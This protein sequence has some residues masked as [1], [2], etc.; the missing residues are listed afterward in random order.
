MANFHSAFEKTMGHEGYYANDPHD[1]GG[2]TYRGVARNR[3]E[4]WD[5]WQIID[6]LRSTPNFPNNLN[7]E[8]QL[9]AS[10]EQFYKKHFWNRFQGD[11][12]TDQPLA[13]ELFDTSVNLGISRAVKFLQ[14]GLNVLN[15][16][17]SLYG[18]ISVDGQFGP[19]TLNTLNASLNAGQGGYLLKVINILQ[20]EHYV[21]LM[22]NNPVMEKY[23]RGWLNR[24][25]VTRG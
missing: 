7:R 9:Q 11:A 21:T 24:V 14:R 6:D 19:K 12:V 13:E 3:H 5:G 1:P 17:G 4:D 18:D 20:G 23:A 10:V 2:E 8:S 22:E 15:K 16:D 25:S